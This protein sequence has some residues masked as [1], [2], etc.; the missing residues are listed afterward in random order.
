MKK[1]GKQSG[2]SSPACKGFDSATYNALRESEER[3]R[4]IF[5]GAMD[6]ILIVDIER[7]KFLLCNNACAK[8]LGYEVE[9]VLQL[10]LPD[11]HPE[12]DLSRVV[13][14]FERQAKGDLG[15]ATNIP[16][17]RKDGSIC[18]CDVNSTLITLHGKKC[19]MGIFRDVSTRR[20]LEAGVADSL[21]LLQATIDSSTDG[22]L[23]VDRQGKVKIYNQSFINLWHIPDKLAKLR[24]DDALLAFVLDQLSEP[25]EFLAKVKELYSQPDAESYD[26]LIFKDGR[27]FERYSQPQYLNN[28]I[29]GRVWSFRDM[30]TRIR[31][32]HALRVSEAQYRSLIEAT[33]TGFVILDQAGLVLDANAAYVRMTG[34]QS[35]LDIRNRSVTEWTID[36]EKEKNTEA[37]RKCIKNGFIRNLD[38]HY[39]DGAGKV[40]PVEINATVMESDGKKKILSI[41]LDITE[42]EKAEA[43]VR[44]MNEELERRVLERTA[45]LDAVNKELE[46]F[47]YSISHDLRAPL[48]GINGFSLAIQ[49]DFGKNLPPKAHEYLDRIRNAANRM[50]LL[51]DDILALSRLTSRKLSMEKVD[52]SGLAT[53]VCDE[54]VR[55]MPD[56]VIDLVIMQGLTVQGDKNLLRVV[57]ENLLGNAWKFT[58][59]AA[60][61][62]IEFGCK[63]ENDMKVFFVKDNGVGF[64]MAYAKKLF[65]AFQ[66]LHTEEEFKGTGIGLATVQRLIRRHGGQVWAEAVVNR[67]ATFYFNLPAVTPRN[68]EI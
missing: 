55:H 57:L 51:I 48:R 20:K 68:F 29:V 17:K 43:E 31:A 64:D 4:T 33:G 47:A 24:D 49:E 30:T 25:E 50:G 38:I 21:S 67:G 60:K 56:R 37:V 23:V 22:L 35:L 5:E 63:Q 9:E 36:S 18:I 6:G 66:R 41:C 26:I 1:K 14:E 62:R 13:A 32:E 65:G 3:F 15:V 54:L 52:I 53:E 8:M 39:V 42:R 11:I 10:W 19:L 2:S 28:T 40:T 12:A 61:P 45:Q 46:S 44:R 16:V 7:K 58:F 34:R 27:I 59:H